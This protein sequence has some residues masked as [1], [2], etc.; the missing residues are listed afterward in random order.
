MYKRQSLALAREFYGATDDAV[1]VAFHEVFILRA[2]KRYLEAMAIAHG[3]ANAVPKS[4]AGE[5]L[6]SL[7]APPTPLATP[8]PPV[9]PVGPKR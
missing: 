1:R 2:G 7:A 4:P 6:K 5:L 8:A 9:A 3:T